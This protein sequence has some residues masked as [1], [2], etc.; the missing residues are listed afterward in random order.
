MKRVRH[1][2]QVFLLLYGSIFSCCG[3]CLPE[4]YFGRVA[5]AASVSLMDNFLATVGS[6]LFGA[7]GL[8]PPSDDGDAEQ[9]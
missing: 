2:R 9:N 5:R 6:S 7:I 3:S 1:G 4:D 8:D